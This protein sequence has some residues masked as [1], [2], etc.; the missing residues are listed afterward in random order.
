MGQF[1]QHLLTSVS[2]RQ[3]SLVRSMKAVSLQGTVLAHKNGLSFREKVISLIGMQPL[4]GHY[5]EYSCTRL[6]L[7]PAAILKSLQ[8]ALLLPL[9]LLVM[10]ALHIST[11]VSFVYLLSF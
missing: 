10:E 8:Q 5:M 2:V 9:T 7:Y 6:F 4:G 11:R 3:L 1:G